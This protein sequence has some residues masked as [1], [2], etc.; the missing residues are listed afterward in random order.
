MN[1]ADIVKV[2]Y[3]TRKNIITPR[4]LKS[5]FAQNNNYMSTRAFE[6][7]NKC[8]AIPVE[9]TY[10]YSNGQIVEAYGY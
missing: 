7:L 1:Y 6:D 10:Q 8:I 2:Y 5:F 9:I 3:N 4:N